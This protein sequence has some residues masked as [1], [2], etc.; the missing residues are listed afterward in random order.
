[1]TNKKTFISKS[2]KETQQIA[3][4]IVN[5]YRTGL[6]CLFGQLGAGK[7]TFVKGLA[8]ALKLKDTPQSPTFVY[9]RIYNGKPSMHH[10]D[11]YR[12]NKVDLTFIEEINESFNDVLVV[13]EWPDIFIK[14]MLKKRIDIYLEYVDDTTREITVEYL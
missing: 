6:I 3:I 9:Q 11:F 12:L 13:V 7:T 1:M 8:R 14:E 4:Q 5:N 10:Y 2:E